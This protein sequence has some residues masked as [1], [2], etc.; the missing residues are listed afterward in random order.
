MSHQ[1][2]PCKTSGFMM[3]GSAGVSANDTILLITGVVSFFGENCFSGERSS[4]EVSCTME[5]FTNKD[6]K[7]SY[8]SGRINQKALFNN[9]CF[10]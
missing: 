3:G 4:I 6:K 2:L 8:K 10:Q 5:I 9:K 7:I 1:F